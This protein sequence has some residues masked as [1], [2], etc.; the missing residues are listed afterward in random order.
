MQVHCSFV[1]PLAC[2]TT[3]TSLVH[4]SVAKFRSALLWAAKAK[5]RQ[6]LSCLWNMVGTSMI[7]GVAMSFYSEYVRL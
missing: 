6:F 2:A 7:V 3:L 4:V 1:Y 5:S